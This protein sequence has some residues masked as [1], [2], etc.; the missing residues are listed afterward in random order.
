VKLVGLLSTFFFANV[1]EVSKAGLV[2][3]KHFCDINLMVT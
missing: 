3:F 2:D 1:A